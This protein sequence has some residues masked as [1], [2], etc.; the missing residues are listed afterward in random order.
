VQLLSQY[1][2]KLDPQRRVVVPSRMR[3]EIGEDE[4]A[5]GL[6]LTRGLDGCLFLYP[7]SEWE[8]VSGRLSGDL[9]LSAE[10][11]ATQ[12]K[13]FGNAVVVV[14]DKLGRILVSARLLELAGLED[15]V[16]FVGVGDR[17]ELW[18][19]KRWAAQDAEEGDE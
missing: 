3:E 6:Y 15:E 1:T 13:V 14:P 7:P 8:C 9:F 11:R 19:P 5:R 10:G 2:Q 18:S 17:I 16:V 12:R 4:L